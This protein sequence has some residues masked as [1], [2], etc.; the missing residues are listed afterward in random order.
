MHRRN[1]RGG[2][3][4]PLRYLTDWATLLY[5]FLVLPQIANNP[6]PLFPQGFTPDYAYVAVMHAADTFVFSDK[7]L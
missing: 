5:R 3:D 6:P 2:G 1:L 7:C 4:W